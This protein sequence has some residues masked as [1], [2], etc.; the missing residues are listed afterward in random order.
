M[1]KLWV[2]GYGLKKVKSILVAGDD[3]VEFLDTSCCLLKIH[4]F[5]SGFVL[6]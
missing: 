4:L 3:N 1:F 2:M 5:F 6:S